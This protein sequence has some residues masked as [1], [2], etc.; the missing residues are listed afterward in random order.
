MSCDGGPV[1]ACACFVI[2]AAVSCQS[3]VRNR[4]SPPSPP[5]NPTGSREPAAVADVADWPGVYSSTSEVGGFTGTVLVLERDR[6][7]SP[8]E[9]DYRTR[10]RTDF[11]STNSIPQS[12][13]SGSARTDGDRLYL[14]KASGYYS[15]G[16]PRLLASIDRYTRMTI[17][18]HA[19][20][21]RDDAL[22][23]YREQ[24]RLYDYGILVRVADRVR[25]HDDLRKVE[26]PSIKLLYQDAAKPWRD[27]FVHGPNER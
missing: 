2:I 17:N 10:F 1:R 21:M 19:V 7:D 11:I 13:Y 20:L 3:G 9:L 18:G 8:D 16:K 6:P 22:K 12:T 15:D 4:A 24:N 25:A 27:P 5:P 14:P 23:A 26:H